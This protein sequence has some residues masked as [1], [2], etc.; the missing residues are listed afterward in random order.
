MESS[1]FSIEHFS[2]E[3]THWP[4]F[5]YMSTHERVY[6]QGIRSVRR[7]NLDPSWP[8]PCLPSCTWDRPY[9][10]F[11]PAL[12]II[13]TPVQMAYPLLKAAA[14]AEGARERGGSSVVNISS[15]AGLVSINSGECFIRDTQDEG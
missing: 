15:V 2:E 5:N 6:F 11:V 8:L 12:P 9:A 7:V 14:S 13:K 10:H 1:R 3:A 4:R